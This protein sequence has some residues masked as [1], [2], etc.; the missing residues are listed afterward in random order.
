VRNRLAAT[1]SRRLSIVGCGVALALGLAACGHKVAHPTV[2]DANNNGVYLWAG[3][4]TYQL[5]I[6]R[7][8]NP[9]N[10]EDREYLAGARPTPL[11]ANE[12]WYA[13]FLWA[14]NQT[15]SRQR[16]TDSFDIIDTQGN[17]YYPIPINPLV[18]PFAWTAQTLLPSGTEPEI[19][20]MA[21]YGP[22]QGGELLFRINDSAYSNRPLTLE[23]HAAGQAQ[24]SMISLDL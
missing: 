15:N 23:I 13:V 14:K 7:E 10:V 20:S 11:P 19:G 12:E 8:L 17:R 6:S 5:Q 18:N 21:Y 2:A 16:T 1:T 24:P 22:T 3:Q 4:V 9:F